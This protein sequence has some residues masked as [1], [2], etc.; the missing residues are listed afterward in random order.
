MANTVF[1]VANIEFDSIKSSIKTYLATQSNF[2]DVDYEGSNINV[3]LDVLAY[4]TYL[5]NFYL[6]MVASESFIDSAQ[7]RNSVV[8]HAK[9]LNYTPRSHSASAGVIDIQIIPNDTP[10]QITIPKY[11][12][13]TSRV[14]N[15]TYVFTTDEGISISANPQGNYIANNVF[16]YEGDIITELFT[17][18]TSNTSQRFVLSNKTIDTNSLVVKINESTTDTTN[19]EWIKSTSTIGINGTTN[20]YYLLP[21]EDEKYE[22]Q[23]GDGVLGRRL[24]NNNVVEVT[25]RSC[26]ADDPNG[27]TD[28]V[29][30]DSIQGY[31]NVVITVRQRSQG[32]A[33]A[34]S[35]NSIKF[36]ATKS[37]AIQDRT[38]TTNDY[39]TILLQQFPEIEAMNVFGGENLSPPQYGKVAISVD[40]RNADGVSDLKRREIEEFISLRAPLSIRPVVIDP[41]FLYVDVTTVVS[42]NP[43]ITT[44]SSNEIKQLVTSSI[45]TYMADNIND[46]AKKLRLSKLAAAI[47]ASDPSI[48]SNNVEVLLEKRIVPVLG[49]IVSYSLDFNNPIYREIP[50]DGK[51]VDG[52][53]PLSS[54]EFTFAGLTGCSLRD[55]GSGTVQVIRQTTEGT[56]IINQ[57]IGNINYDTGRVNIINFAVTQYS[58]SAIKVSV[59][60]SQRTV[61]AAKNI[62]LSYSPTPTIT[63][64]QERL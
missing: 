49:A 57:N 17:V 31:S 50:L 29:I 28:F 63:I 8:S 64:N 41:E 10:A 38:I 23:F 2:K 44:K 58:G 45:Q 47:D 12:E 51:F 20:T 60:P 40:L 18:D 26:S 56:T 62:I 5:N 46:F 14:D 21:A 24:K 53:S 1:S 33:I 27:A 4:N 7:I 42:Y 22:L 54:T 43:N 48:L 13:F 25:Y 15:V 36:N 19:T 3:L 16:I 6:N 55:N 52:T 34:E 35:M 32:G 59:T 61:S 37:I 30:S 39:K 11:T 9:T